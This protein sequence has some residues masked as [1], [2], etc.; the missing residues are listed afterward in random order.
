MVEVR[1]DGKCYHVDCCKCGEHFQILC[2]DLSG[3]L[4]S[5]PDEVFLR[6]FLKCICELAGQQ[7]DPDDVLHSLGHV[8]KWRD[9]IRADAS[10][11]MPK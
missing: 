11:I 7:S 10:S 9:H 8:D 1:T 4:R 6:H 5:V 3:N 2:S